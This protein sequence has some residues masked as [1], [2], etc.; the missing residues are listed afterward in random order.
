M[1][2]KEFD[3]RNTP[4][5]RRKLKRDKA[6]AEKKAELLVNQGPITMI[7]V[8]IMDFVIDIFTRLIYFIWDFCTFGF[9]LVYDLV[10]GSYDGV[11]PNSEKFGMIVS[12]APLRYLTTLLVPPVGVFLSKGINGWFNI[13]ICFILTFIHFVFGVIY[14]FVITYRNRYADRYEKADYQRLM[15][16]REYVKSCTGDAGD[17]TDISNDDSPQ[18]LIFTIIFFICFAGLLVTAFKFL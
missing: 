15:I 1:A 17:I 9:K 16:I 3:Y 4:A 10:Y 8:A 5:Y 12:M 7:I 13:I 11:I 18:T 6:K 2:D 14:A